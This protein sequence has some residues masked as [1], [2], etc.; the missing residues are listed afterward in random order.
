MFIITVYM[1]ETVVITNIWTISVE[2]LRGNN[3][4]S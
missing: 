4:D 2:L 3:V 1:I